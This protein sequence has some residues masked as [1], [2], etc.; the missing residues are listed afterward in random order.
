MSASIQHGRAAHGAGSEAAAPVDRLLELHGCRRPDELDA[1]MTSALEA[2]L[3]M[4]SFTLDVHEEPAARVRCRGGPAGDALAMAAAADTLP[5]SGVTTL[6]VLYQGRR[7]G[8]LRVAPPP[9]AGTIGRLGPLLSHYGTALANLTIG[10]EARV[11]GDHY[12]AALQALEE[13]IVLF[14]EEARDVVT[15]RFLALAAAMAHA[16]AAALYRLQQPGDA[17]SPLILDQTLGLPEEM[18]LRLTAAGEQPWPDLLLQRPAFHADRETDPSLGG[19]DPASVPDIVRNLVSV[20]LSYL[21]VDTGICVLFNVGGD[22]GAR[23][24]RHQ[25]ERL[26]SFGHLGAALL[27]RFHLEAVT[28]DRRSIER[29]LQIAAAIQARL[30]PTAVPVCPTLDFAW[31]SCSANNI[32]G[33]YLDFVISDLGDVNAIIADASGHGINSALLMSS[34]RSTY[35]AEAPWIEPD[36]LCRFLN[37]EVTNE[38]GQ[39]GMFITAAAVRIERDSLVMRVAG[40]GHCPPLLFQRHTGTILHLDADGPPLGFAPDAEFRQRSHQLRSGDVL[41][42]Y[43]DGISEAT[44]G[45]LDMFG[46]GRI[47]GL[48]QA[49]ASQSAAQIRDA[50]LHALNEWT[51]RTRQD[52]DVS[53]SVVKVR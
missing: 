8:T 42:L 52:D 15:A 7:L 21:G 33:D 18:L 41:L 43:T 24:D 9:D 20:P 35:R 10:E 44:N 12:C 26:R 51:G 53:L 30:L 36:S 28:A 16:P 2:T 38:V 22:D 13:G 19:L 47:L 49:H 45:D 1:T 11:A 3:P 34:F 6:P 17:T 48:L 50:L 31:H 27:H 29:E 5:H 23:V 32:G 40:A 14:Q 46:E 25:L 37:V 4:A 39:T